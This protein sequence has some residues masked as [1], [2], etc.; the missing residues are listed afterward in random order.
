MGKIMIDLKKILDRHPEAAG[1]S[2]MMMG[3]LQDHYPD[4][5]NEY[6]KRIILF[7]MECGIVDDLQRKK[8]NDEIITAAD[9]KKY[10]KKIKRQY[11]IAEEISGPIFRLWVDALELETEDHKETDA[12]D[13]GSSGKMPA[14]VPLYQDDLNATAGENK[15]SPSAPQRTAQQNSVHSSAD[16]PGE[17]VREAQDERSLKE[18]LYKRALREMVGG[19]REGYSEARRLFQMISGYRD[20]DLL[21]GKCAE[22]LD[23]IERSRKED[24][25]NRALRE[26]AGGSREGYSEARRLFQQISGYEDADLLEGKCTEELDKIERS[27]KED[28]YN[29]ALREMAGRSIEGYSEALR[30]FAQIPG[31]RDADRLAEECGKAQDER[32]RKEELYNSAL[33]EMAGKSIEGYSEARKLFDQIPGYRDADRLAEEC[34]KE[35]DEL[36]RKE[37]LYNRALREMAGKSTEGYSEARKFFDQIPGYRDADRLAEE[38]GKELDELSRK[39]ELYNRALREMAGKSTEGYS[40]AR[41]FFDQIPGYRDADRLAEECGKEL[42]ELSRKEELY[43]RALRE[44]AGKSTEGYSE[45]RK[46]FDQIPGYRDADRLAEE[47]AEE[48]AKIEQARKEELY[49]KALRAMEG[50]STESYSEARRL[51]QQI[52]GYRDADRLAEECKKALDELYRKEDLYHKALR[53]MEK[54]SRESYSEARGLFE[55]IPGYRDA[56]RL[57]EECS[58]VLDAIE[59]A[60]KEELYQKARRAMEANSRESY[61]EARGLLEQISGYKDADRLA[62]ECSKVLVAI[63]REQKEEL[64]QRARRAMEENSREGYSEARRLFEQ[65]PGYKDANRLTEVCRKK[66][67]RVYGKRVYWLLS[68]YC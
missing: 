30:L 26:M 42:D 52:P 31:Y 56:D 5:E 12:V 37:E 63:D 54:K 27:R 60:R 8:Q 22:E 53:V 1:D 65:I 20:A 43:N 39:E 10:L 58:K 21:E 41:K 50:K 45:A 34:G 15:D 62:E 40:E 61:S 38:C 44:M 4:Y 67:G 36:S 28:L 9:E 7:F 55:Q 47:C 35:L 24:L 3:L 29:R 66:L 68:P 49:Q 18:E 33:R 19:N 14:D 23:K 13:D 51:F 48:L 17:G 46:L 11:G 6:E 32:S 57:A 64:Y 25:Y 16:S 2:R 59:Q